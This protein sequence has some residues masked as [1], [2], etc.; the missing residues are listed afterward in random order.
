MGGRKE[1]ID[2]NSRRMQKV[3]INIL[4]FIQA[5]QKQIGCCYKFD[6]WGRQCQVDG[7]SRSYCYGMTIIFFSIGYILN[8]M[9]SIHLIY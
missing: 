1:R 5:D 2:R 7:E 8:I 6:F 9:L 4:E 3:W